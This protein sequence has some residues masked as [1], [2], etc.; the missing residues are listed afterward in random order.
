M[1]LALH[2]RSA[3]TATAGPSSTSQ[4]DCLRASGAR[5]SVVFLTL[6]NR[7]LPGHSASTRRY[8]RRHG[9][10]PPDESVT[11]PVD[12]RLPVT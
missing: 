9:A 12:L 8:E 11:D 7:H 2:G 3:P 6:R 5:R 1:P 10:A 4:A